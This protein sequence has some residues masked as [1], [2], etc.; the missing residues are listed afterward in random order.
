MVSVAATEEQVTRVLGDGLEG[1]AVNG[2][3]SVG[4][5]R[6]EEAVPAAAGRLRDRGHKTKRLTVSHAFHSRRM[7]PMLADFAAE[8]TDVQGRTPTIPVISNVTGRLAA[9]DEL[10]GA[11]YWAGHVRR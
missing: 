9:P 11:Q 6:D 8:L 4:L 7:E 1:A 3:S 5:S 2:P 10:T